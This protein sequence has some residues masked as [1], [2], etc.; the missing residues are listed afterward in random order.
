MSSFNR[1]DVLLVDGELGMVSFI[2][3]ERGELRRGMRSVVVREFRE[4][5]EG[6]PVVLLIVDVD[7]EV[8]LENLVDSF[9]LTVGFRMIRG[10][11][12]GFDVEE[13]HEGCPEPR[14][15][16]LAAI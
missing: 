1:G 7:T 4:R 8:L 2:R 9:S 3:K 15:E 14:N 10:G 11:E 6:D 5:K 12:V 13:L 16:V